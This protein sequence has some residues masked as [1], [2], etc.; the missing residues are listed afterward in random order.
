MPTFPSLLAFATATCVLLIAPGPA[1]TYV[2]TRSL[3]ESR[4]AGLASVLGLHSGTLVYIAAAVTGLTPLLA[5][6]ANAFNIVKY[7]GAAYLLYL[8]I[9][10][11]TSRQSSAASGDVDVLVPG[12]WRAYRQGAIVNLLNPKLGVFFLAFVPQFVSPQAGPVPMQL[13]VLGLTF[14]ALGILID[15]MWAI[16]AAGLGDRVRQSSWVRERLKFITGP[17]YILLGVFAALVQP[18]ERAS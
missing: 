17:V 13:V 6:S 12:M 10:T 14:A 1:M 4:R 3:Q 9:R 8:G 11:L 18:P 5:S 16:L 2:V 7:L 15:G